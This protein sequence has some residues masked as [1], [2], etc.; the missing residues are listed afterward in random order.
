MVF[1]QPTNSRGNYNY[2]GV[3]Y[4]NE[5]WQPHFHKNLEVVYCIEGQIE[6]SV[7]GNVKTLLEHDFALFL[8]NEIHSITHTENSVYWIGVF[9]EDFVNTFAKAINGKT[10]DNFVFKCNETVENLICKYLINN[11]DKPDKYIMKSCFYSLCSEYLKSV[12]LIDRYPKSNLLMR[13]VTEYIENNFKEDISLKSM[14]DKIGYNYH[15]LSKAFKSMFGMSFPVFL[16][17]Y[18]ADYAI[19]LL[20]ETDLEIV[21]IAFESGFQSVRSFNDIFKKYTNMTPNDFR[22]NIQRK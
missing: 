21:D 15:Y 5:S 8:S 6:C 20:T 9:S 22:K 2:N 12:N 1:H 19:N 13:S 3:I 7:G 10:G 14:A 16:S 18:R 17:T 11:K 4:E